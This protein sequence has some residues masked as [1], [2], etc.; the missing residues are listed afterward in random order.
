MSKTKTTDRSSLW[1]FVMY[2]ESLPN[3]WKDYIEQLH[4][5]CAVSPLHN[6]DINPDGTPKKEHYHALLM[7]ETLKS[8][9]QVTEI[10]APLNCTIPIICQSANGL[11]RYFSHMDNPEKAQYNQSDILCFSGAD[12]IE[13]TKKTATDKY[14]MLKEMGQFIADNNVI[15]YIDFFNYCAMER[16]NDWFVLLC[17]N[18]S[19]VVSNLITSQR[20]KYKDALKKGYIDNED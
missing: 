18:C 19:L 17:D 11:V 2:P 10:L 12:I 20:N 1:T 4:I 13:L 3:D 8:Q 9:K 5:K 6:K 16:P 14:N 7:F 15:E